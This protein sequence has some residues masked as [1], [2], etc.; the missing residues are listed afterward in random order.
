MSQLLTFNGD[1][2]NRLTNLR[3]NLSDIPNRQSDLDD[4]ISKLTERYAIQYSSMEGIVAGLKDTG[5]MITKMLEK[6]DWSSQIN[7]TNI[8]KKENLTCLLY[9]ISFH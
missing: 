6:N 8:Y 1:I 9:F 4:R 2:E 5:D 7:K 3:D